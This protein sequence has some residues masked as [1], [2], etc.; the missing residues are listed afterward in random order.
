M[1]STYNNSASYLG[2]SSFMQRRFL[3]REQEER[4][5][6]NIISNYP[7]RLQT[8]TTSN[9]NN[10]NNN[11][12][13]PS[14][15]HYNYVTN[16]EFALFKK[17][18]ERE[19]TQRDDVIYNLKQEIAHLREK[20]VS[21]RTANLEHEEEEFQN[22]NNNNQERLPSTRNTIFMSSPPKRYGIFSSTLQQKQNQSS[23]SFEHHHHHGQDNTE[24]SQQQQHLTI[25]SRIENLEAQLIALPSNLDSLEEKCKTIV[26]ERMKKIQHAGQLT[27]LLGKMETLT[28][29]QKKMETV[30]KDISEMLE[31]DVARNAPIKKIT[32][33]LALD[34]QLLKRE[35]ESLHSHRLAAE[36]NRVKL[37]NEVRGLRTH[38]ADLETVLNGKLELEIAKL[39]SNRESITEA[40][41]DRKLA[42]ESDRIKQ[43]MRLE[44]QKL[45][46][47]SLDAQN[48]MRIEM[49]NSNVH[50]SITPSRMQSGGNVHNTSIPSVQHVLFPQNQQ[51][52]ESASDVAGSHQKL[53]TLLSEQLQT[54]SRQIEANLNATLGDS[55]RV[56]ESKL[57]T[58]IREQAESN[59]AL[60]AEEL[61]QRMDAQFSVIVNTA[62]EELR[63]DLTKQLEQ[64]MRRESDKLVRNF[65]TTQQ[66][67]NDSDENSGAPDII[68]D[69]IELFVRETKS[70]R[71]Q[72]F[73]QCVDM[74]TE[75]RYASNLQPSRR[76]STNDAM[77]LMWKF[78][79]G[80]LS[81]FGLLAENVVKVATAVQQQQ[82]N[83]SNNTHHQRNKSSGENSL[84]ASENDQFILN[85]VFND[86]D[87]IVQ[88]F[89]QVNDSSFAACSEFIDRVVQEKQHEVDN[90]KELNF[91]SAEVIQTL[92][93]FMRGFLSL[94]T[95]MGQRID[96]QQT[97]RR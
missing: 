36:D 12:A 14:H 73:S 82:N 18:V 66:N 57:A 21:Q 58:R 9:N 49:M 87:V 43:M 52:Q 40:L 27:E 5:N 33:Q 76:T 22:N 84:V 16:D 45:R 37:E 64:M 77:L 78:L 86:V 91:S 13:V 89:E 23:A 68:L 1:S 80:H 6:E 48:Q 41:I 95:A 2:A 55:Q 29:T 71:N 65:S 90:D 60:L 19:Q 47:E 30:Q 44:V 8:S 51:H 79:R 17:F 26:E 24:A 92:W 63:H 61:S 50:S 96:Q 4:R 53:L 88:Q 85:S 46:D 7:D 15:S 69:G 3:D 97:M 35:I 38:V 25:Q 56:L 81:S 83:N 72:L 74:I 54:K 42:V 31:H 34:T 10:S 28:E 75:C 39:G 94:F 11:V 93:L 62:K 59:R 70:Q 32:D 67:R 20:I